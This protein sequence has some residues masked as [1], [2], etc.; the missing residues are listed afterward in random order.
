MSAPGHPRGEFR[1]AQHEGSPVTLAPNTTD[2]GA[3]PLLACRDVHCHYTLGT[4]FLRPRRR[5]AA[6][7]GVS[8]RVRRGQTLA[9]VGE[10]GSGKTTLA[11]MLLGTLAPS[12]GEVL[13]DGRPLDALDRQARAKRIQP[14]FQDPYSSLNPTKTLTQIIGMPLQVQGGLGAGERKDRVSALMERVGLPRRLMHSY[15]NQ[16]SG[17]QRQR[18][19]IARALI[20]QPEIVVLDEPTSALD[21]SVQAQILNLLQ[22]LKADFGLTYVFISHNLA[23]VDYMAD[24]L[25]VMNRGRLVEFG[26]SQSIFDDPQHAYTQALMAAVLPMDAPPPPT[27][28]RGAVPGA[29]A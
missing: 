26:E 28:T 12:Q 7:D 21:V 18:V 15:P 20:V 13:L 29:T 4:G 16:L 14:V 19:S 22:E 17:G 2:L 23:V 8:L 9:I 25:A 27:A 10:S 1:S 11:R 3:T 24:Q 5:L 6:V